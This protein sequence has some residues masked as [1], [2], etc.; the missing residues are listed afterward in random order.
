MEQSFGSTSSRDLETVFDLGLN[1]SNAML[2]IVKAL[3]Y[4]S[5]YLESGL[6]LRRLNRCAQIYANFS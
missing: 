1:Q 6:R 2:S 5:D 3:I 4:L